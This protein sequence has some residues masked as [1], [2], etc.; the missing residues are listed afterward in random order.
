MDPNFSKLR[1]RARKA[2][3]RGKNSQA[4]AAYAELAE[5]DPSNPRWPHKLGEMRQKLGHKDG[6]VAAF[7]KAADAYLEKGFVLKAIAL[8]K[9]ILA[10]DPDNRRIQGTLARLHGVPADK[11]RPPR[12]PE[13]TEAPTSR[14]DSIPISGA[15]SKAAPPPDQEQWSPMIHEIEFDMDAEGPDIVPA[16]AEVTLTPEPAPRQSEPALVIPPPPPAAAPTPEPE[17]RSSNDTLDSIPITVVMPEVVAESAP[18]ITLEDEPDEPA[19]EPKPGVY[20]LPIDL[21]VEVSTSGPEHEEEEEPGLAERL[22]PI[23]LL[24]SLNEEQLA[25]FVERVEVR[26]YRAGKVIIKQGTRGNNLYILVDGSV[27][28]VREGKPRVTLG[29]L[30]EGAFFGEYA[31]LTALERSATVEAV[32]ECT[33]LTISRQLMR[34]LVLEHPPVFRLLLRFFR[35][36]LLGNLTR[37]HDL[38]QPFSPDERRALIGHF[39]WIE[40]S[41]AQVLVKTGSKPDGLYMLVTGNALVHRDGQVPS[42]LRTGELF[43]KTALL[44]R[45]PSSHTVRTKTKCWFL[46]LDRGKFR[47]LIM[48]HPHLLATLSEAGVTGV[49]QVEDLGLDDREETLKVV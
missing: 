31:L 10:L 39:T 48:T 21:E 35:D 20:E 33:V 34:S 23:P 22:P 18:D 25:A 11:L 49:H 27:A 45:T 37:T 15:A 14:T 5:L 30:N 24:S 1:K 8:C 43:C 16:D 3:E 17:A 9:M 28:V 42:P 40:A 36:R 4:E 44:T 19:E 6:A 47:E 29:L 13:M 46:R 38:F 32:E 12:E 41:P 26:Q 7:E 2:R